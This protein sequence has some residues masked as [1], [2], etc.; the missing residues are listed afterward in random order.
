MPAL[1]QDDFFATA[2]ASLTAAG[3]LLTMVQRH[4]PTVVQGTTPKGIAFTFRVDSTG[5]SLTYRNKAA[6]SGLP[7]ADW[8][9]PSVVESQLRSTV[10]AAGG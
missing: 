9:V 4:E 8:W 3:F 10:S 6:G 2:Q 5:W 7:G 1:E